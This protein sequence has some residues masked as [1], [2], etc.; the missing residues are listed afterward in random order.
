M[1]RAPL[2]L[3]SLLASAVALAACASAGTDHPGTPADAPAGDDAPAPSDAPVTVDDAP[4]PPADAPPAVTTT[5][6]QTTGTTN[7]S[8]NST[9]CPNTDGSTAENSWYRVFRLADHGITTAFHVTGVTV[10][11]QE[12]A[13]TQ[14]LQIKIGSYAGTTGGTTLDLAQVTPL[15]SAN[16]AVPATTDPG[17]PLVAPI[18]ADI[19]AG[20]TLIVEVFSPNHV[21]MTTTYFFIGASSSGET[22]PG[23][24]RAPTCRDQ[25]SALITT[26]RS[27]ASLGRP[28]SQLAI[29]VTGTH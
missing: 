23:Y 5:L 3:T 28:Q 15:A 20:G 26:P 16:V 8:M 17:G 18:T 19:P 12:A 4:P 11:V 22:Q 21:G 27:T 25:N 13:G 6:S 24:L 2:T 10:G 1:T 7:T 14:Q 29:A 9:T